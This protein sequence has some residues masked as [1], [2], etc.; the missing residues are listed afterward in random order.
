MVL[1]NAALQPNHFSQYVD[2]TFVVRS[3]GLEKLKGFFFALLKSIHS[4]IVYTM[5]L[6]QNG[7][8][9]FLYILIS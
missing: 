6:E 5:E 3:H 7:C 1:V 4:Y 2:G 9:L 8:L